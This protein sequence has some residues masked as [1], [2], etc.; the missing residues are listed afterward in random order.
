MFLAQ[1][2]VLSSM[3]RGNFGEAVLVAE[4]AMERAR[5]LGSDTPLFLAHSM[6]S[7]L[8]AYAGREPRPELG[9]G[10]TRDRQAHRVVSVGRAGGCHP[11]IPRSVAGPLRRRGRH[12]AAAGRQVRSASTPT[13][14]P[15]AVFL[16]DAIEAL[17]H[18]GRSARV[19]PSSMLSSETASGWTARGRWP[20]LP[21]AGACCWPRA[22]STP[23]ARPPRARSVN[24]TG[25]R[26]RSSGPERCCNWGNYSGGSGRRTRVGAP[27]G[28][29]GHLRAAARPAVGRPC[30]PNWPAPMSVP[31]KARS[32]R[33]P[34]SGSPSSPRRA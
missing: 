11:G 20:S 7:E 27:A 21:V 23:P 9:R 3:W 10:S 30:T 24:T 18:A 26:C 15:N 8:A 19:E 4:D 16:P 1:H 33:R 17:V 22:T 28:G 34:N 13:E 5:Q 14:L 32:S 2:V 29:A 6:R 31:A 12:A 25:C